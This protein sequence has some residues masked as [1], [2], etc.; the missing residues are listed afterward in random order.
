M[1]KWPNK[2]EYHG[3]WK[4]NLY[5]GEGVM[6]TAAS[7]LIVRAIF[8]DIEVKENLDIIKR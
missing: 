5:N 8:K 3:E 2:D 1:Y 7:G 6:K 4:N